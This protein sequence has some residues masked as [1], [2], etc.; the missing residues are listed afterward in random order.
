[1]RLSG[2]KAL[3]RHDPD[4]GDTMPDTDAPTPGGQQGGCGS[5]D[6]CGRR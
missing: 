6:G 2:F 4:D 3:V 5:G 1:M